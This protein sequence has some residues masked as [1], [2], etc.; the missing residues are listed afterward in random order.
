MSQVP[1]YGQLTIF[2]DDYRNSLYMQLFES[3]YRPL[4]VEKYSLNKACNLRQAVLKFLCVVS[5]QIMLQAAGESFS[6][7]LTPAVFSIPQIYC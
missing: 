4:I 6:S 3:S 5:S 2:A 7:F 1:I